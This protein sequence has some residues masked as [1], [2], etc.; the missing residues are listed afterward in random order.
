MKRM[1]PVKIFPLEFFMV[2]MSFMFS[3]LCRTLLSR[4]R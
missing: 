2:F 3:A 1:E 4:Y